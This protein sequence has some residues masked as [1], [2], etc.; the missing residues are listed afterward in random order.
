MGALTQPP[1]FTSKE[2]EAQKSERPKVHNFQC[3]LL[4]GAVSSLSI[5]LIVYGWKETSICNLSAWKLGQQG[6]GVSPESLEV[7]CLQTT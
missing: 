5:L 6:L 3:Q 7:S 2:T 1:C 4:D